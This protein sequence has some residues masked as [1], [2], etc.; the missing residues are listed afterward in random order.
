MNLLFVKLLLVACFVTMV[1]AQYDDIYVFCAN[2]CQGVSYYETCLRNC[3]SNPIV[4]NLQ[5]AG[6]LKIKG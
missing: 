5:K 3:V 4:T 6:K 1:A 2:Q